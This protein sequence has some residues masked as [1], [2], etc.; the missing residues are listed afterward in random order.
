MMINLIRSDLFRLKKSK[1]FRKSII[2]LLV[3]M[4]ISIIGF[5]IL[6]RGLSLISIA[7]DNKDYGFHIKSP[8]LTNWYLDLFTSSLGFTFIIYLITLFLVGNVVIAKYDCGIL[9][10]SIS[11]G[12]DRCRIYISN[13][14]SIFIAILF[15]A[16]LTL[17]IPFI[18]WSII[19][20]PQ[21]KILEEEL[22]LIIKIIP[23]WLIILFAMTSFYVFLA[24]ISKSKGIVIGLGILNLSV[25]SMTLIFIGS[26][27][28]INKVPILMLMDLCSSPSFNTP[29]TSFLINSII[30]IFSTT[31]LGCITVT[32]QDIK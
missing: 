5:S 31:I 32:N 30:I 4:I 7:I 14:I 3:F 27:K 6:G 20:Y 26:S 1:T 18:L 13:L 22:L 10:N 15:M 29:L 24:T 19:F 12:H 17:V 28:I 16:V 23:V 25:L 8:S 11:S 21:N 9:K 2:I